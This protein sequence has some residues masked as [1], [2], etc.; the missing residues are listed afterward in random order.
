M[1]LV[2]WVATCSNQKEGAPCVQVW[3]RGSLASPR[4]GA[5]EAKLMLLYFFFLKNSKHYT[6]SLLGDRQ[7]QKPSPSLNW[8]ACL[9]AHLVV[10]SMLVEQRD[11]RF[12]VSSLN[13]VQS[14]GTLNQDTV[15]D[16]Q[17]PWKIHNRQNTAILLHC[18]LH[19]QWSIRK[20]KLYYLMKIPVSPV[21]WP[22]SPVCERTECSCS[23]CHGWVQLQ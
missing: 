14:L 9:F 12:N 20:K 15:K 10:A 3:D 18:S 17:D 5:K 19:W 22:A 7:L 11:Y 8:C 16:F 1:R 13:D 6:L 4:G 21:C 23:C 2:F